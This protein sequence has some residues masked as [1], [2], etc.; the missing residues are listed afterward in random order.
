V[1][2]ASRL[3][4]RRFEASTWVRLAT[5]ER[6]G[7]QLVEVT[8][9]EGNIQPDHPLR[10]NLGDKMVLLGY[11]LSPTVGQRGQELAVT[12]YWQAGAPMELDYTV[13]VHMIGPDGNRVAQHDGQPWW[14]VPLPT[15]SWQPGETLRDRHMLNLP[16]DLPPRAYQLQVGAY[17]W[18]T[19]KRLPVLVDG[20]SAGDSIALG[21]VQVE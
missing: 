10:A 9:A 6:Q 14:E 1:P 18:Q 4:P 5:F 3:R 21:A 15:S 2:P 12:L 19:G 11:D 16:A 20:K 7:R 13:F 17:Y 8:P